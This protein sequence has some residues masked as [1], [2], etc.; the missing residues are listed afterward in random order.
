MLENTEQW[1]KP[2][3]IKGLSSSHYAL[4]RLNNFA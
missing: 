2:K 1:Q 3:I 4:F